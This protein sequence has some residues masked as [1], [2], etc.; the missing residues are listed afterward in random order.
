MIRSG[1]YSIESIFYLRNKF[2]LNKIP[3]KS[4]SDLI[5]YLKTL[6]D[7]GQ[8]FIRCFSRINSWYSKYVL[9]LPN[10]NLCTST[11]SLVEIHYVFLSGQSTKAQIQNVHCHSGWIL[12][13]YTNN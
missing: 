10:M 6:Q 8:D 13:K 1:S 7:L 11:K 4:C 9:H 3:T 2:I 5:K 12:V